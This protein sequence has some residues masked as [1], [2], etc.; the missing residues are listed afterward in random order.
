MMDEPPTPSE[1]QFRSDDLWVPLL[2]CNMSPA[3]YQLRHL[4]SCGKW[5]VSPGR[6][7]I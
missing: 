6:N 2:Q 7:K 3:R 5:V 4:A 1:S